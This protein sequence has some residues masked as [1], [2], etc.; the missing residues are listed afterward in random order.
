M[1][2]V[3]RGPVIT[4]RSETRGIVRRALDAAVE[5]L[6]PPD[7][8]LLGRQKPGITEL[9]EPPDLIDDGIAAGSDGSRD[10]RVPIGFQAVEVH[11]VIPP[12]V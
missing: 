1:R 7:A 8:K 11:V 3:K 4:R 6:C 5:Q 10:L 9:A 2:A 12:C